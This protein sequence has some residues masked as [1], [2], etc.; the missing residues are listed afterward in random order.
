MA[1]RLLVLSSLWSFI[2]ITQTEELP[3]TTVEEVPAVATV[4][5]NP[6]PAG[7]M[8]TVTAAMLNHSDGVSGLQ[9]KR[10]RRLR[11]W[12]LN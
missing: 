10:K 8:M 9:E 1:A 11:S 6:S 3:G 7:A 5:V 2:I 4:A 12:T